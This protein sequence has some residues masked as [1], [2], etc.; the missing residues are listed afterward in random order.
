[1]YKELSLSAMISYKG[2]LLIWNHVTVCKQIIII[3]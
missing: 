3:K 1:M 2:L